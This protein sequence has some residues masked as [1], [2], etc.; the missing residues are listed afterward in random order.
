M[1]VERHLFLIGL[2]LGFVVSCSSHDTGKGAKM[3]A[4]KRFDFLADDIGT[5]ELYAKH[6][7]DGPEMVATLRAALRNDARPTVRQNAI[8]ALTASQDVSR[9]DDYV[10]G[11]DDQDPAVVSEA[12]YSIATMLQDLSLPEAVR[13]RAVTALRT[14][15]SP[16]RNAFESPRER[17]RFNVLVALE[18]VADHDFD[19]TK[20]FRDEAS[21]VRSEGL[22]LAVSRAN[23]DKQ[24]SPHDLTALVDFVQQTKDPRLKDDA[25]NL[26]VQF[27]P[28]QAG[29]LLV[30]AIADDSISYQG[31]KHLVELHLTNAVPAI[32][33]YMK[34]H[35]GM[36]STGH[37][38]TLVAFHA[39]CA[40]PFL[41][42]MLAAEHDSFRVAW[43]SDALRA[44]SD[45]R[46]LSDKELAGWAKRQAPDVA[47]CR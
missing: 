10:V 11:L 33:Q 36:W 31:Y 15:A 25:I 27:A 39:T 14:H 6:R 16:L 34:S 44:L 37:L 40:A 43:I 35:A 8:V 30:N 5:R 45:Q 18:A 38:D 20:A 28:A 46:D 26:L 29:P 2:C 9:L 19:V 12:G 13:T 32:I 17:V 47:P 21:L 1:R 42:E 41:A 23:A 3:T 22:A 7:G 4:D 24:L